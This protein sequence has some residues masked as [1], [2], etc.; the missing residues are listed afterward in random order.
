MLPPEQGISWDSPA[1][2]GAP[3]LPPH[4]VQEEP[5]Y[6]VPRKEL[7]KFVL[8]DFKLHKMLGKGSFGKVC[9][10]VC[11]KDREKCVCLCVCV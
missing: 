6:A 10:C 1:E 9:V 11:E 5:L 3:R 4:R 2:G 7:H 8:D